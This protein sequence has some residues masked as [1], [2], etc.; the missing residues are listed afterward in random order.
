MP[1]NLIQLELRGGN[2][3]AWRSTDPEILVEGPRGTGK[4]RTLLEKEYAYAQKY[5]GI[6]ILII[7]KTL[8][9]IAGSVAQTLR[10]QVIQNGD[11]VS[12]FGGNEVEPAAFRFKNGSAIVLGGLDDPEKLKSSEYT[13]IYVNEA[14]E[15]TADDWQDLKALLRQNLPGTQLK[16]QIT[17]DCNPGDSGNWLNQACER[18]E[19]RRIKTRLQDNPFFFNADG[20]KTPEGEAYITGI[21]ETYQGARRKRWLDG[22]WTGVSDAVYPMFDRAVH[23]RPLEPGLYFRATIIGVDY[24]ALHKCSVVAMSVDQFNRRWVREVWGEPD[25]DE[26]KS[27]NLTIAQFKERYRTTR[28]RGD[29]NQRYLNEQHGFATARAGNGA[30]QHRIDLCEPLFYS[31]PGGRVPSFNEARRLAVPSGPFAEP[32]SPGLFLVEG[33]PGVEDLAN[34]LESYHYIIKET[35]KGKVKEVFRLDDDHVAGFEYA[36]EEW[37]ENPRISFPSSIPNPLAAPK[38][39]EAQNPVWTPRSQRRHGGGEYKNH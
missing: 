2:A 22:E 25:T 11:G 29:P 6:R 7:R 35:D 21:L 30:R 19:I 13:R 34:E 38:P 26:G 1:T 16:K 9:S 28:G 36:N 39:P 24:G 20:S 14:T 10:Q 12:F 5:P 3:E 27:L 32:D 4:S 18:G 15:I 8:R 31:Y 23:I 37:E 17:G 33:A